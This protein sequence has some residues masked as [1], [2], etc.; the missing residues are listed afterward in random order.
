M[1]ISADELSDFGLSA[2]GGLGGGDGLRCSGSGDSD[3]GLIR[4]SCFEPCFEL[5]TGDFLTISPKVTEILSVSLCVVLFKTG[6]R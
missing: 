5:G 2:E 1:S 4:L 6:L 3:L